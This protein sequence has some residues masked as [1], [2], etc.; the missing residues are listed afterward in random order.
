[1]HYTVQLYFTCTIRTRAQSVRRQQE[2][3]TSDESEMVT[4]NHD[5]AVVIA[6]FVGAL[7]IPTIKQTAKD[8]DNGLFILKIVIKITPVETK[9]QTSLRDHFR[10]KVSL[11]ECLQVRLT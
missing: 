7:I 4:Y 11:S 1:M 8:I 2:K 5:T 3:R 9:V 6:T 10:S